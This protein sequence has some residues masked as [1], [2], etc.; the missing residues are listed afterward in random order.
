MHSERP[1]DLVLFGA[2]GFTGRL[3]AEY[4][5]RAVPEGCRWALAGRS[6]DRLTEVRRSLTAIDPA[7][8]E[9]PLLTADAADR[10]ALREVAGAARVVISTVGPYLRHGE[11]LVAACADAGTDY[12]D[13]TGEPEF[14][15]RMYL[16]HHARAKANGARLVHAC[17]FDS[18]PHDLG[19]LF[20][21]RTLPAGTRDAPVEVRGFV[22]AGGT[23]SGGTFAS[24]LTA[25]SRPRAA[26]R[27]ARERR[28]VEERPAGRRIRTT[29]DRPRWSDDARAWAWPLPTID[30]Q[31]V[32]RSAA[33]LP[34]YG[35]DFRY[36]HYAAVKHLPV[37]LGGS[38]GI[39]LLLAAAQLPALRRGL[40]ALRKP[41]EG[42]SAARRA[43]SW[44]TVRFAAESG[45][46]RVWTEVGG[47]DPGYTETA[48]MLAE[49]ALSLAFDE[50]PVTAGQVTPAVAMGEAL[51]ER[52]QAAGIR[53]RVLVKPPAR[54]PRRVV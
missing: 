6:L 34:L 32:G 35:P 9:L 47:G 11:P 43:D 23:F 3:T 48:K 30:A 51:I 14:V 16:L 13:L 12:V 33:A 54:A 1:Y 39:A 46:A 42:P 25:L 15:D 20:T 41:G 17:G 7:L 4:L 36:G 53:F 27:A 8:A 40:S 2:T 52:L 19:V 31:V 50:L 5:A 24:A 18:V 29:P 37:A 28:A 44:F 45:G 26:A 49:S 10:T 21:V 22:R 38:A